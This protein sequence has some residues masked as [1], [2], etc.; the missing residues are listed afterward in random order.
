MVYFFMY[1]NNFLKTA[2]LITVFGLAM[3]N[4]GAQTLTLRSTDSLCI[5]NG[6]C[7]TWK[8]AYDG[9]PANCIGGG[10][11]LNTYNDTIVKFQAGEFYLTHQSG[12]DT[13]SY[14]GGFTTGSNGD[15]LCYSS[16]CPRPAPC[17]QQ[18]SWDWVQNQWG[19]MAGGGIDDSGNLVPGDPYFI[20]YWN[21]YQD[22]QNNPSLQVSLADGSLFTPQE[23]WICN[24]PWPYWGN[25]YGDGFARPLDSIGDYF[26]LWIHAVNGS[27]HDSIE[28]FLAENDGSLYQE[29]IWQQIIF[30]VAWTN[31]ELLYFTMETTDSDPIYG[32]NTAV[33]F[34]M[35]RLK[36][37]KTGTAPAKAVTQKA[38]IPAAPKFVEVKDDFPLTSYT[39]GDVL[40]YDAKGKEVWRTT[41]KA[42]EKP[43]LSKLPKG[44][45][46]LRHGHR[47][48]PVKKVK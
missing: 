13:F 38:K 48:I 21:Y 46:R 9:D 31:I 5:W 29:S 12:V 28:W 44:E 34:N 32:P 14:W 24:H 23:V 17:I 20:A 35:D 36:V 25:I 41:V 19:V 15:T 22:T 7:T 33:Y 16:N 6:T 3:M 11:W 47:V 30:P 8:Y 10:W 37:V 45:Y 43:N 1:K 27:K 39:G 18:G 42:G 26:R 40:L 4:V 2:C